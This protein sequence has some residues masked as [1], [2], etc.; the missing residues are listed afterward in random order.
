MP[1]RNLQHGARGNVVVDMHLLPG[2]HLPDSLGRDVVHQLHSKHLQHLDWRVSGKHLHW[3]LGRDLRHHQW[4]V[5]VHPVR[6]QHL[7]R[8]VDHVVHELPGRQQ[9]LNRS[10]VLHV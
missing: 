6:H 7:Q 8:R 2:R 5:V 1:H 9:L 4:S 3:L 10:L